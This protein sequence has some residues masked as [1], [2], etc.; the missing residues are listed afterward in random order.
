[1]TPGS[2]V[3]ESTEARPTAAAGADIDGVLVFDRG[4]YGFPDARG[5][6][7]SATSRKGLY[8]LQS[9]EYDALCLVLADP[10]LFF[11]GYAVEL[12]DI[13]AAHLGATSQEDVVILVTVTLSDTPG[14]AST[15]NLQGPIAINL[16][17]RR[18]RQ[19]IMNEGGFGVREPLELDTP[20]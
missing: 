3:A 5:F 17:T 6:T 10:F 2:T 19:I 15:A 13:D 4:I 18:G 12:S 14:R 1:M 11:K 20:R 9:T 16:R 8:W 7:L